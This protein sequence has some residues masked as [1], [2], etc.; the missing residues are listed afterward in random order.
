V[1][2][3]EIRDPILILNYVIILFTGMAGSEGFR[4][5]TRDTLEPIFRFRPAARTFSYLESTTISSW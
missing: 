3:C 2:V 1:N 5:M 4:G